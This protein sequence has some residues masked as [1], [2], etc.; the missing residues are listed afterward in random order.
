MAHPNHPAVTPVRGFERPAIPGLLWIALVA[1]GVI[2]SLTLVSGVSRGSAIAFVAAGLNALILVGLLLGHR[3][4]YILLMVFSMAGVA[5]AFSRSGGQGLA[6]L[7]GNGI[8]VVPVLLSSHYFF[9]SP[10]QNALHR[11]RETL[12][13]NLNNQP[14]L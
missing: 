13:S 9:G 6:V 14:C 12:K 8:V 1:L 2:T 4:A 5:V 3:W 10:Q 11:S 7:I